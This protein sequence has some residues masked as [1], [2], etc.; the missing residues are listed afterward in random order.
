M[1]HGTLTARYLEETSRHGVTAAELTGLLREVPLL[2]TLRQGRYLSRPVFLG[3]AER[4]QLHA[5]VA[6]LRDALTSL[7]GRL[8]GGDLAA[9]ARAVGAS[10]RQLEAALRAPGARP[11]RQARAD[12]YLDES[13]FKLLEM[14][15]GSPAAGIDSADYCRAFL[16]HPVVAG[17]AAE[18]GLGFA[19]TMRAQVETIQ[20]ETG[21]APGSLPVTAI[22][23]AP[24]SYQRLR[25]YLQV[26][27]P[28]W[29][30]LGLDAM[31]CEV[32]ELQA[33]GG[34]V[35]LRGRPV[36]VVFRL[37]LIEHVLGARP[38]QVD[39]V[40]DAAARGEVAMYTAMDGEL[41][42]SKLALAMLS[43]ERNRHLFSAGEL[44]SIDRILPWTR[45][46][47]PGPV[48][49]DDGSTVDLLDY[50]A[51]HAAELVLKPAMLHGG[52]GVV[53]G[54]QPGLTERDWRARLT[55]AA[56]QPYV[57]QRR[58][59]PVPELMPGD[60]GELVPWIVTWGVFT[61]RDGHGGIYTR[62]L[63]LR[64]GADVVNFAGGAAAGAAMT[65]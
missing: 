54:W 39:P 60:D 23:A 49:L 41:F 26:L 45:R 50:A 20:D 30:A 31:P 9:F 7:P 44:A 28:R 33:K 16:G 65:A 14:N 48:T 4:D 2:Q 56:G 18:H 38:A 63:P 46:C 59:R 34:R 37:F 3:R 10:D 47:R 55:A 25:S 15:M 21:F 17:F 6:N 36:D 1:N 40:L 29:R 57:L 43:D 61:M 8:F 11:T 32:S 5:D 22:A 62:G 51:S 42:S 24:G 58:V 35:W 52:D 19:D 13:G 53:A 27:A 64:P 12:L